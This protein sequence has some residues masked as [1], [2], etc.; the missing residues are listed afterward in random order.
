MC[1]ESDLPCR[2]IAE[3]IG[4][5]LKINGPLYIQTERNDP[6]GRVGAWEHCH[7][8]GN[9]PDRRRMTLKLRKMWSR[10]YMTGCC[11]NLDDAYAD[12]KEE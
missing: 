9:K 7:T 10:G 1:K 5:L 8:S 3:G 12:S 11:L 2:R 6:E 4:S